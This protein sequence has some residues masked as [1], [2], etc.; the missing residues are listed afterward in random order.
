MQCVR[1][2]SPLYILLSFILLSPSIFAQHVLSLEKRKSFKRVYLLPGD[3][4]RFQV[5]GDDA[6]YH[7]YIGAVTKKDLIIV[8]N[9]N[10]GDDE[11]DALQVFKD[12]VPLENISIIYP[13][14]NNY[15]QY[16][17]KMFYSGTM[18]GGSA[19]VGI[20]T[21]NSIIDKQTPD[22]NSLII[23]SSMM[24]AGLGIRYTGRNKYKIGKRWQLVVRPAFQKAS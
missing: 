12:Y 20:A 19:L 4:I 17:K 5:Q 22:L 16:F 23:V 8:K 2:W 18:A 21:V 11:E 6:V 15:W 3:F 10:L 14:E 9:I 24:A 7:G 1:K 13:S